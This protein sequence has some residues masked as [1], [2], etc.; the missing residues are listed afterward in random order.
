MRT[1]RKLYV[2][3][4][5]IKLYMALYFMAFL[6]LMGALVAL[7]GGNSLPL[8]TIL[9][10]LLLSAVIALLQRLFLSDSAD[11]SGGVFFRRSVLW[12]L[13]STLLTF[14]VSI[15]LDWFIGYPRWCAFV[16]AALIFLALTATLVGL[17][18]EQ[19]ADTVRLNDDLDRFKKAEPEAEAPEDD[20]PSEDE[21]ER[22]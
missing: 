15:L 20:G 5:G 16:L 1:Y 21:N 3:A 19:D 18:F 14:A 13:S 17:K 7:M 22:T 9:E 8:W 4:M 12:L 10:M 11:Y 2:W 6:V